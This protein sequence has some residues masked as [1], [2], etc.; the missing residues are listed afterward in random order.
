M[1]A[2]VDRFVAELRADPAFAES[3]QSIADGIADLD[4]RANTSPDCAGFY[5]ALH[6]VLGHPDHTL[7]EKI[8]KVDELFHRKGRQSGTIRG[9]VG[10]R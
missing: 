6:W 4:H 7:R 9:I 2:V 8:E 1:S 5:E 10:W 3:A